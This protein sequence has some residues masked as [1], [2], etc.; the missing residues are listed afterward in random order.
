MKVFAVIDTNV[1]VSALL[2]SHLDSATSLV[3][4]AT[5]C[6][7]IIPLFNDEILAEYNEVLHR[8]KL[9]IKNA[10]ANLVISSI[11]EFGI[12]AERIAS[13]EEFPDQ[14]DIVFYEVALSKEDAYLV[15]GNLK[16]FPKSSRI[17]SPS[18]MM[19]IIENL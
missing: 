10:D 18:E 7:D 14:K 9:R 3:L 6:G 1:L 12:T 4:N 11:V 16:H 8:E 5:L 17:V 13:S 15:S 2:S 19:K